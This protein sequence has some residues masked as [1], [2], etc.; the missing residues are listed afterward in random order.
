VRDAVVLDCSA[1]VLWAFEDEATK[2]GDTLLARLG[3]GTRAWVP[4]IWHLEVANVLVGAQSR[5]RIDQAG[6]EAFLGLLGRLAIDVDLDTSGR[7][8]GKTLDLAVQH[9]LS[10]YDAAY[11][12]LALRLGLPLATMDR[13]L[14]RASR[15]A[16][17]G[18]VWRARG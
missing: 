18:L 5:G 16:G 2:A 11:L 4:A 13:E 17:G 7:A 15:A 6:I 14:V 3:A 8:W 9:K 12:E 10:A 1:A